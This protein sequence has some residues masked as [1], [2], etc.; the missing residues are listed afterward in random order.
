MPQKYPYQPLHTPT[1]LRLLRLSPG[2]A[3]DRLS[4]SMQHADLSTNPEYQALSYVWGDVTNPDVMLCDN[5]LIPITR[6][7]AGALRSLRA[8][9]RPADRPA[10][11][12]W[13]WV[14]AVCIDQQNIEEKTQQI[15]ILGQIY[16][17][18]RRCF[19]L[20]G[21]GVYDNRDGRRLHAVPR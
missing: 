13:I 3:G 16:R 15:S 14:D 1:S 10:L 7:L 12:R 4:C 9:Q 5:H 17:Q 20:V 18:S 11:Y 21:R 6:S 8:L 2:D 19:Y